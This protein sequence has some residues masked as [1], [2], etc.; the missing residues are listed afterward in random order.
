L[1]AHLRMIDRRAEAGEDRIPVARRVV[2]R[3]MPL[4]DGH[5]RAHR[6]HEGVG[7]DEVGDAH[8]GVLVVQPAQSEQP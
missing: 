4:G 3:H 7:E 5:L 8:M 1:F 6:D 2:D